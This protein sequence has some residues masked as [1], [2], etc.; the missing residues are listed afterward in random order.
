MNQYISKYEV[1]CVI[2]KSILNANL[3]IHVFGTTRDLSV[4]YEMHKFR[5]LKHVY[6]FAYIAEIS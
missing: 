5:P 6:F 3:R 4:G 2:S 1:V